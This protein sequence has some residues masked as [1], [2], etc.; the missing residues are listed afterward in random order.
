MRD[1][2]PK[3]EFIDRVLVAAECQSLPGTICLNKIDLDDSGELAKL[4]AIYQQ[5]GYD[6]IAT[7]AITG[8]GLDELDR[9]L[10]SKL[11]VITGQS[12]VG[13]SSLANA[14]DPDLDLTV[15]QIIASSRKGRHTTTRSILLP[16]RE[17]GYLVDTPGLRL[18][19]LWSIDPNQLRDYF[20]E[21]RRLTGDCRFN[22]CQHLSEPDC[23]VKAAVESGDI[24]GHRYRSYLHIR[25]TL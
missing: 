10:T 24:S 8:Y 14:L 25:E 13:K 2:Y 1:P 6:V 11:T 15:G 4:T 23:A 22:S 9:Y 18:F 21:F 7:S 19:D 5:A 3:L 20:P 17:R 16:Y 12:G